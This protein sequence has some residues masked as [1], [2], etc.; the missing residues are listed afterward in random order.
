VDESAIER[1]KRRIEQRADAA[2]HDE[3]LERTRAELT[4]L[5]DAAAEAAEALPARVENA[6]QDGLR[7]Q[8]L[9]V[10]RNLA[11]IRGLANQAIRRLETLQEKA[12]AERHERVDDLALLVDLIS[13][14]WQ[15]VDGRLGRIDETLARLEQR[16]EA[17]AGATVYRL[18][19]RRTDAANS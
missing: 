10:G 9:P 2:A 14:G 19:D 4:A 16:L 11:E 7:E 15:N 18:D 8:V 12:E 3:V 17:Q 13:S 1:A 6:V 5:A